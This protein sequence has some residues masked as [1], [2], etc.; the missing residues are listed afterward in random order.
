V[1]WLA[2]GLLII[3]IAV[4]AGFIAA[5]QWLRTPS[6]Q[7]APL[8]V[9]RLNLRSSASAPPLAA[10]SP[11]TPPAALCVEWRGLEAA[12]FLRAREQLNR[13]CRRVDGPLGPEVESRSLAHE[14]KRARPRIRRRRTQHLLEPR[15]SI[16]D[17]RAV[18]LEDVAIAQP[19]RVVGG[20]DE[21]VVFFGR[22]GRRLALEAIDVVADAV[23]KR[24]ALRGRANTQ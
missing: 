8:N 4:A 22:K 2:L 17:G 15:A 13:E 18:D 16:A 11:K 24:T 5:S 14:G 6:S 10:R 7:H 19:R 9:D 1:K 21:H 20:L 3:N 23:G 12:D